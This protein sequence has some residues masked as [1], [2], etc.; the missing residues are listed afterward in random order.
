MGK[1][2]RLVKLAAAKAI[3]QEQKTRC[4]RNKAVEEF[5]KNRT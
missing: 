1:I 2:G 5:E 3:L 4:C